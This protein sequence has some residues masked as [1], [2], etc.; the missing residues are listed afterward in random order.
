MRF[1]VL[2]HIFGEFTGS[3]INALQVCAALRAAG[4]GAEIG[5]FEARGPL[6]ARARALGIAVRDL[7]ADEGPALDHDVIWAHHAPVLTHVLFRRELGPCR[8][9]FSS[10]SPLTPMESPPTY[11]AELDLL[12]AHSPYNTDHLL[13]LGADARRIHYFPNFAPEVFFA[14]ARPAGG[15]GLRRMAVVSNHATA[16]VRGMARLARADGVRVDFIGRDRPVFVDETVLPGYDL[17]VTIGK[18][19]PYAFAQRVPVYCYDHFGGPGYLDADNF[20][21]ARHGNFCGRSFWRKLTA[22]ALWADI[23]AGHAKAVSG[24]ALD[25][26]HDRTRELF[27]LE[28]NLGRLCERIATLPVTDVAA[29]RR[30]HA[31]AGRLNDAYMGCLRNRLRLEAARERGVFARLARLAGAARRRWR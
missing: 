3:E 27:S 18:T 16:E 22:D 11:F 9:V 15:A 25:F 26:L 30:R 10:L 6:L 31:A 2:N 12:L 28:T 19:V 24:E 29:L 8:V 4:H 17:A 13:G 23:K 21:K 14:R 1:L 7:L 5:T 20:E